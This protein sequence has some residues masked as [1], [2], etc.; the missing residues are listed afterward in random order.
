VA[1]I[2]RR[3]CPLDELFGPNV[4]A[5]RLAV[6]VNPRA[7]RYYGNLPESLTTPLPEIANIRLASSV[8]RRKTGGAYQLQ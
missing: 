1:T 5:K 6:A 2:R 8:A 7:F 4:A 3:L